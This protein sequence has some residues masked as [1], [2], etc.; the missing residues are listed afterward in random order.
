MTDWIEETLHANF[1]FKMKVDRVLFEGRSDN[2]HVAVIEN[3][4]FGR[5]LYLDGVLQTSERDEFIYHE[6]LTHVPI[7]GHGEVK[8]LLIIGGG[9]G[10]M[11]EEALK[12]RSIERATMVEIDPSVVEMCRR[13]LPSISKGAFDDPR[14]DLV[15][16]DGVDFVKTTDRRFDVAIIDSTDPIGPGEVLFTQD[17][18]RS[19]KAILK[20]GGVLV[21][22]NGVPFMQSGEL[23]RSMQAFK[24]LFADSSCYLAT[25]PGYVGGPMAFGWASDVPEHRQVSPEV[26]GRRFAEAAIEVRYYTPEVHKAA[27]ALPGY[28]L[29]L[30]N[31]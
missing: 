18:Y 31:A 22:Q 14:T 21:T 24:T 3:G 4:T 23:L 10:G 1:R 8:D 2:Q 5:T 29:A 9:D 28:V 27:F 26:L 6:M 11:L 7:L 13:H 17:F 19:V 25:V 12:H 20:D 16:A 30:L 15:F